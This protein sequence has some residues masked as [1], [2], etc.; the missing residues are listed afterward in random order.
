MVV[1]KVKAPIMIDSTH[2][3]VMRRVAE[4]DPGEVAHQLDNLEDGEERFQKVVPLA[5]T[6]GAALV[7]GCIDE[8][9]AQAGRHRHRKLAIASARTRS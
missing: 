8:D 1:K 2:R 3:K 9:K 5:R 6:F 7:V 4:A